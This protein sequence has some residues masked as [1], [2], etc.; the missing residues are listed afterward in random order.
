MHLFRI[1]N[2]ILQRLYRPGPVQSKFLS[3][4]TMEQLT[5]IDEAIEQMITPILSGLWK[6]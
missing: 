3:R 5:A 2:K 1:R 6:D 4:E